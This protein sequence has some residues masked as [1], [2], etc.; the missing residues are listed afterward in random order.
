MPPS[1]NA[2]SPA[3]GI[4]EHFASLDDPRDG[5]G[6]H[7]GGAFCATGTGRA[8][9]EQCAAALGTAGDVAGVAGTS[10]TVVGDC[11]LDPDRDGSVDSLAEAEA[12]AD[13]GCPATGGTADPNPD[14]Y[15]RVITLVRWEQGGGARYALQSTLV[16]NPGLAVGPAVSGLTQ[17]VG[18]DTRAFVATTPVAPATVTWSVNGAVRGAATTTDSTS[19]RFD[20]QLGGPEQTEDGP[21]VVAVQAFNANGVPGPERA[22]TV[23]LDRAAPF[24]PARFGAGRNGRFVEFEWAANRERDIRGYRVFLQG[25][26]NPVCALTAATSCQAETNANGPFRVVAYDLH[27]GELRPGEA[28]AP[29]TV[30]TTN[31]PPAPP[32]E[33][34]GWVADGLV[35]LRWTASTSSDVAF[36][37]VYRDGTTARDR[38]ATTA[39]GDTGYV[40]REGRGERHRYWVVAVDDQL[41]ESARVGPVDVGSAP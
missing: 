16:P 27:G 15:K 8:T 30:S 13:G 18:A 25:E 31:T 14:D 6:D 3:A 11:G 38:Y 17:S 36:Y 4:L 40:D 2:G 10:G 22:L 39:A 32:A 26:T 29:V 21:Y 28:S 34:V 23:E 9:P 37:R 19:W 1:P 41:A 20:W 7:A 12:C 35:R 5:L 24:A 33:L